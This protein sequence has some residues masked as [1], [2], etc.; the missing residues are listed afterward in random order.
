MTITVT[1]R[2]TK[3]VLTHGRGEARP[4]EY[5]M[6]TVKKSV[7]TQYLWALSLIS[8]SLGNGVSDGART[9]G[10]LGHNQVL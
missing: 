5:D 3:D 6:N 4:L 2:R 7:I 1:N 8:V 9:R 10:L